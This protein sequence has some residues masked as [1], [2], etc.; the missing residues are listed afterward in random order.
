[1]K[2]VWTG[3]RPDMAAKSTRSCP[4]CGAN[5]SQTANR[6][7]GCGAKVYKTVGEAYSSWAGMG[8][9]DLIPGIRDLPFIVRLFLTFITVLTV[10]F[11]VVH[12]LFHR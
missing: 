12:F 6:C 8:L 2:E 7:S 3:S 4:N 11:L 5:V 1:M 9:F 10:I